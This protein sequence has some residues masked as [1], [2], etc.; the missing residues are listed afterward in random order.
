MN[1]RTTLLCLGI[2]FGAV[3]VAEAQRPGGSP[4]DRR[5]GRKHTATEA[6]PLNLVRANQN[7]PV[8]NE[9]SMEEKSRGIHI[10]SNGI[11]NHRIGRFPNAG[12]P[13]AVEPQNHDIVIPSNPEIQEK[14]TYMNRNGSGLGIAGPRVFGITL[15]GVFI[16][17]G[18]AE[19]WMGRKDSGWNFEALGGAVPLGLDSNYGHVQPGGLYHYHGL[20]IDLMK[21]LGYQS[22]NHSPMIGW[23]A[24]GFPI[25]VMYG[26]TDPSNPKSP[27][28]ELTS[29][30]RLKQG[31]RP[32]G[33]NGPGG[34]YDG[35]F[36]QDYEFVEGLGT[37]DQ[38]NGR[39]CVTPE[40]PEGTYAYF[41]S[42]DWPV[43]PRAFQ[44]VPV[45]LKSGLDEMPPGRGGMAPPPG[46]GQEPPPFGKG[47]PPGLPPR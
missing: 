44:G 37:L 6:K 8:E 41:F 7:P 42:Q 4:E 33:E 30:H 45:D 3:A 19:T 17:P 1:F 28:V 46:R 25:Y 10:T 24:D 27:V 13:H 22:G 43:V 40:F 29:S 31:S 11:P 34:E 47:R 15:D 2:A 20:P 14:V 16:E 36:I 32:S 9:V 12:N 35:A 21:R 38:C 5:G 18:T 23:A 26:Y 39:F